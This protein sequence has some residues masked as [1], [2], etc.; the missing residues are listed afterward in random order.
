MPCS[1]GIVWSRRRTIRTNTSSLITDLIIR[2]NTERMRRERGGGERRGEWR[3]GGKSERGRWREGGE[4][5]GEAKLVNKQN[6]PIILF[7]QSLC[8]SV[9]LHHL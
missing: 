8:G 4:R 5:E 6:R 7:N 1:S 3:E 2:M 9:P